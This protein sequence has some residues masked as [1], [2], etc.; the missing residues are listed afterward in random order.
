METQSQVRDADDTRVVLRL[1]PSRPELHTPSRQPGEPPL[2]FLAAPAV[3]GY[4]NYELDEPAAILTRLPAADAVLQIPDGLDHD[5]EV[6]VLG[7]ARRTDDEADRSTTPDGE[8][9]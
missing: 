4:Q 3:A 8:P 9:G 1:Q 7:P 6:F 2:E 5:I